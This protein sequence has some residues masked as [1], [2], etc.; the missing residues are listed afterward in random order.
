[1]C[2]LWS[3]A[4]WP[5]RIKPIKIRKSKKSCPNVQTLKCRWVCSSSLLL[6]MITLCFEELT[7][8]YWLYRDALLIK[9]AAECQQ[10]DFVRHHLK[11]T[12]SKNASGSVADV[13][14]SLAEQFR[15]CFQLKIS[16]YDCTIGPIF[17]S[18]TKFI[19]S[20]WFL[21]FCVITANVRSENCCTFYPMW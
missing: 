13:N 18:L 16:R 6:R 15:S 14:W 12:S 8:L 3:C 11:S 1:M 17:A 20:E 4:Y 10:L 9:S 7:D 2:F 19:S 5:N 21:K